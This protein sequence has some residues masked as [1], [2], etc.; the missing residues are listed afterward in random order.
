MRPPLRT[1][2][3]TED[4]LPLLLGRDAARS[5]HVAPRVPPP[6]SERGVDLPSMVVRNDVSATYDYETSL[7]RA[8]RR[9]PTGRSSTGRTTRPRSALRTF[10]LRSLILLAVLSVATVVVAYFVTPRVWTPIHVRR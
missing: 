4:A 9:L 8:L 6:R 10:L 5:R 7:A 2:D 3:Y 1:L